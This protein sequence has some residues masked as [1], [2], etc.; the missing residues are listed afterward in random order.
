LKLIRVILCLFEV[1]IPFEKE[2][3][4]ARDPGTEIQCPPEVSN[5]PLTGPYSAL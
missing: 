1:K 3:R 5:F 4:V 2:K